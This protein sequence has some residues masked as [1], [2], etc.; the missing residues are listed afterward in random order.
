MKQTLTDIKLVP[1]HI[2]FAQWFIRIRWVALCMLVVSNFAI[3]HI[4]HISVQE[5]PIYIL[6]AILCALNVL[7]TVILRQ[8]TREINS[9][10]IPN[11]KREIDFQ[12]VTDLTVLTLILHF[13]GGI[14]NPIILFYF[15]HMIIAS[16]IF[17]PRKSYFYVVFAILL[18]AALAFLE[19]YSV[20]PHYHM[21]GFVDH[22]LYN[23][24]FYI[25]G[26]GF[27][28]ICTSAFIVSLSHRIIY[29][30]INSEETYF[31]TNLELEKKD[32]LKDEYVL[33]VTHD[34]KGHVAAI[35]SCI[36][37][38]RSKT[39]G[40]LNEVQEEFANRAFERTE[41]LSVFI[42]NLLNL[43]Q[44]RLKHDIG[45]EEFP[46]KD[47]IRK[48]IIPIQILARERS[49]DFKADVDDSIQMITGDSLTIEE[50][51]SNL[52][53]NAVK[54]TPAGGNVALT[55]RNRYNHYVT[56]ISDSG[57]GI[58]KEELSKIFDEFY[59]ASNV[60]RDAKS[61]SGLGL[62]IVKQIIKNHNGKIWVSSELGRWTKFTFLL[63]KDPTIIL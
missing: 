48:V 27:I 51:Y 13:S 39:A 35:L 37:V 36:E 11:I 9:G 28:F 17:S 45:F 4:L 50:L 16:F 19:C 26:M 47:L 38:I 42:K 52:L 33:H 54:Y 3:K 12:I 5:V 20:I 59:R 60:P 6:S 14:E 30:S 23:N 32:K 49:I 43:A 55:V 34:I 41:F 15:F 56:E 53:L 40:P 22:S 2:H 57:I 10:V 58:P 29:K 24:P 25:I 18:V 7:H 63:P 46:L 8:I 44:K 31:K 21:E 61:G 62:S 1:A